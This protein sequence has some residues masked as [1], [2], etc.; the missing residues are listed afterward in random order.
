MHLG[1]RLRIDTA[2]R[3]WPAWTERHLEARRAED[4][5]A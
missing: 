5:E 2:R 3:L 1:G 4:K